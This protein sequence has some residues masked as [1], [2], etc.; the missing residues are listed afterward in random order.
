MFECVKSACGRKALLVVSVLTV[1]SELRKERMS[2]GPGRLRQLQPQQGCYYVTVHG[3]SKD[4]RFQASFSLVLANRSGRQ[5]RVS[6]R[7]VHELQHFVSKDLWLLHARLLSKDRRQVSTASMATD[8]FRVSLQDIRSM[9]K[10]RYIFALE[11]M[12]KCQHY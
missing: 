2:F 9:Y 10:S 11:K 6:Q 8:C 5:V 3:A 7:A 12:V 1:R 4:T